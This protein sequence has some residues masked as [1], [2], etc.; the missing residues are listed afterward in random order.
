[1]QTLVSFIQ[2]SDDCIQSIHAGNTH[3]VFLVKKPLIL[4]TVSKTRESESQL[5]IQLK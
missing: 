3:F 5:R 2:S 1:M 4:V